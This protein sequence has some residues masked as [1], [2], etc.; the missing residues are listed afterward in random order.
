MNTDINRFILKQEE[1]FDLAYKEI[2]NGKKQNHWIWYIFPQ[3]KGLG[4]SYNSYYYGIDGKV[5]CEEYINN[6]YLY[7]N[8]IKIT[9]A[10]LD[11]ENKTIDEIVGFPDNLKIQSSMTL[12][13]YVS[14]NTIFKD[15]IDKYYNGIFD[16]NTITK[17]K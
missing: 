14:N 15:I 1:N 2:C 13:Y 9:K 8:L 11:V 5:E 16:E 6:N 4:E 12:F 7:S 10:L 17:L 3:L